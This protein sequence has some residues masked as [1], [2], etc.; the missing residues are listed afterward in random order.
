[1]TPGWRKALNP[2][3]IA[4]VV[5][6]LT[7][8]LSRDRTRRVVEPPVRLGSVPVEAFVLDNGE[9]LQARVAFLGFVPPNV[10]VGGPV[11]GALGSLAA[12]FAKAE[13]PVTVVAVPVAGPLPAPVPSGV[14]AA[15]IDAE[16]TQRFQAALRPLILPPLPPASEPWRL[17]IALV[18][19]SGNSRGVYRHDADGVDEMLHR[20]RHVLEEPL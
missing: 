8:T 2:W 11:L 13:M 5:G 16:A 17:G 7:I 18:D 3:A 1:M 10:E 4:A 6:V 12:T 15:R 19:S 14:R 9:S 20:A